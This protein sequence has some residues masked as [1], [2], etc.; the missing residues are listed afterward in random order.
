M[1]HINYIP[2]FGYFQG[3]ETK[4]LRYL[5]IPQSAQN[6]GRASSAVRELGAKKKHPTKSLSA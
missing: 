1:Y 2:I 3:I 5:T 6:D 4:I